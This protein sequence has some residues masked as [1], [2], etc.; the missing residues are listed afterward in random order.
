MP[1]S[2]RAWFHGLWIASLA[3]GICAAPARAQ[4]PQPN[5]PPVLDPIEVVVGAAGVPLR[6]GLS[7][8][9]S[10]GDALRFAAAGTPT[11][12]E[13]TDHGDGTAQV[14]WL[15]G[16]DQVGNHSLVFS[17]SDDAMPPATASEQY[18]L[19]IGPGNRPPVLEPIGNRGFDPG[20]ELTLEFAS[21]DP[22]LDMLSY[23]VT[24]PAGDALLEDFGDGSARWTWLAPSSSASYELTV[25]VTDSGN[26]ALS[27][28]ETIVLS[29][30][31]TNRPPVLAPIG[32]QRVRAGES[33]LVS[34]SASDPDFDG[35][36]FSGSGLP[37]GAE[38]VN[39]GGGAAELRW[40]PS[41]AQ[42]GDFA[43]AV[44][45]ADDAVPAETD[46][47]AFAI[48][49]EAPP[50]PPPAE[51]SLRV[52]RA[53]WSAA[54]RVLFAF[55]SGAKPRETVSVVDSS[56][57]ALMGVTRADARGRF[58]VMA[59]PFVAPCGVGARSLA[60]QS[61][62]REVANA[63]RDCGRR[64]LTRVE[65]VRWSCRRSELRVRATRAP[66]SGSVDVY[67]ASSGALLGSL[68]VDH[69]TH[70]HGRLKL[71]SPPARVRLEARSGDGL[72]DLGQFDVQDSGETCSPRPRRERECRRQWYR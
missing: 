67:D 45:V 28:S 43:V 10:D 42:V 1:F 31:R 9:D 5:H 17:V 51:S 54:G 2:K 68:S 12:M 59:A 38:V 25:T 48:H 29:P 15:P 3:G 6:I 39:L 62:S 66:A 69:H 7:A 55:G 70:V 57:H 53:T 71:D 32:D 18:V 8:T 36:A 61:A 50:P 47:E 4:L 35:L 44:A 11:G 34:L 23:S 26:P 20:V 16:E 41:S 21:Q 64:A 33:L 40:S 24:P 49:V 37:S 30:N 13:L 52:D 65:G 63:P 60:A 22:D 72:W 19:T 27:A 46:S 14:D 58:M 56:T